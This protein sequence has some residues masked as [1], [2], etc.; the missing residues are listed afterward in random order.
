VESILFVRYL[1]AICNYVE[2]RACNFSRRQMSVKDK[3]E[4][5]S[6]EGCARV[7]VHRWTNSPYVYTLEMGIYKNVK[8]D[9]K[10]IERYGEEFYNPLIYGE[11]G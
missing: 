8:V 4:E 6:K 11:V 1:A 7:V 2:F 10:G 9:E 5:L 3:N